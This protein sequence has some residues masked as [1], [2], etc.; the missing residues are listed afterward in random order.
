MQIRERLA[1]LETM[2][3]TVVE[4]NSCILKKITEIQPKVMENSWWI[5]KVKWAFV[6][7]TVSGLGLGIIKFIMYIR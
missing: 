3:A 5:D 4:Q 1:K 2:M 6:L 7:L